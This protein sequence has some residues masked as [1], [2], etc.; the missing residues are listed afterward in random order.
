MS[1]LI[2]PQH[3]NPLLQKNLEAFFKRYPYER[4][5]L[6]SLLSRPIERQPVAQVKLPAAPSKPPIR[7]AIIAGMT[8]PQFIADYL[9]DSVI[10][11]DNYL[12]FIVE[13]NLEQLQSAF[14]HW[15]LTQLINYPKT[16][17]LLMYD[18]DTIKASFFSVMKREAVSSMMR[19]VFII[20]TEVPQTPEITEFYSK[21]VGVYDETCHHVLHNFGRIDDSLLGVKAT[22]MNPNMI[23]EYPGIDQIKD[24]YKGIPA[25]VV[26]AG[27]STDYAI[28]IIKQFNDRILVIA[29]D[30]A[31]KPLL[32]A[33]IRVDFTTSVE[34][35]NE[36]QK[37]FF[38]GLEPLETEL[39][40]F[41]VLHQDLIPLYPGPVRTCYRN[42]SWF[43]YFE[44]SWPK[45]IIR[46]G[47]ST[48]HLALG[49][50]GW[51]G[52]SKVFMVGVDSC[53][54][55]HPTEEL[56][57]SHCKDTGYEDWN[58]YRP[59]AEF[60]TEKKHPPAFEMLDV[61]GNPTYTNITYYQWIKEYSEEVNLLGQKMLMINC[62]SKGLDIPGVPYRDLK[63]MLEKLDPI[64]IKRPPKQSAIIRRSLD[65]SDLIKHIVAWQNLCMDISL[66]C[67]KILRDKEM[68]DAEFEV[69]NAVYT[70]KLA[71]ESLF[72]AF[73]V[74]CC[75]KEYFEMENEWWA[76]NQEWKEDRF[77][78][79]AVMKKRVDLFSGVLLKL[80]RIFEETNNGR[81]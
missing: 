6:E 48:S 81:N 2:L 30:A 49:L 56:Y 20:T 51:L 16:E 37:P 39:V 4:S 40:A 78:K 5:R 41:P 24:H 15:D 62:S 57:R 69:I 80:I 77:E 23:L 71:S 31:L 66:N 36:Y 22:F 44:K 25:V 19:N 72:V 75:A 8:S 76:L 1:D 53:Y 55:K 73:V 3:S 65:H 35:L 14:Q 79:I 50:A 43:A 52:C 34:R 13:N 28:P 10:R 21:L 58:K 27:A 32:K 67:D 70:I 46:C 68:T 29:A 33:G 63:T 26:G 45:G 7:V 18:V 64:E 12:T 9:N 38:E 74:Q 47:G 42:Y 59:L 11:K 17:W 61:L 54:E 60:M